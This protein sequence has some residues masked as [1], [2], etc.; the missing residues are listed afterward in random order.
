M[1]WLILFSCVAALFFFLLQRPPLGESFS[2]WARV[3][4][5]IIFTVL[6]ALILTVLFTLLI[7][8]GQAFFWPG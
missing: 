7:A 2:L 6:F 8:L 4:K 5:T 3:E 1:A